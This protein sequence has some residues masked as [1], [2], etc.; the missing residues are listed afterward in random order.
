VTEKTAAELAAQME[1]EGIES[2]L[3]A[4]DDGAETTGE[5]QGEQAATAPEATAAEAEA[6][7]EP[8]AAGQQAPA[9]SQ[10]EAEAPILGG[11]G[12]TI[13]YAVLKETRR[14][15]HE[16]QQETAR[17]RAELDAER[18]KRGQPAATDAE[19]T[20]DDESIYEDMPE[21]LAKRFKALD[22]TV[23]QLQ[24]KELAAQQ[25]EQQQA[26]VAAQ[27]A[28]EQTQA[29][30]DAHPTLADWQAKNGPEWQAAVAA[31]NRL[32]QSP[33]WANKP[34]AERIAKAAELAAIELGIPAQPV[35][36]PKPPART[37]AAQR[38]P[39]MSLT[40]LA[41]GGM[42]SVDSA[43]YLENA[44]AAQLTA[45]MASMSPQDIDRLLRETG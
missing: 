4:P 37:T 34:L 40:D 35:T 23:K 29:A 28:A 30:I 14:Q 31:D 32:M 17:L 10:E 44:S 22:A 45:R 38:P 27:T 9:G 1:Q 20:A 5:E 25:A 21:A 33:A 6:A 11:G 7:P 18:A 3:G 41:G 36:S 16:A 26:A 13:P 19:V 12:K 42:P 24:A 43:E 15:A 39:V 2:V 8:E